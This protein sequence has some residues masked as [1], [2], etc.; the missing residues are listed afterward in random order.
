M[1]SVYSCR[2]ERE[3]GSFALKIVD[4]PEK[5]KE[6]ELALQEVDLL[7]SLDHP[8]IVS[9]VAIERKEI[10]VTSSNEDEPER[11]HRE[12][13]WMVMELFA[14]GFKGIGMEI[15]TTKER[16]HFGSIKRTQ[17]GRSNMYF[18]FWS[19]SYRW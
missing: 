2:M 13:I 3:R 1:G 17:Y 7:R 5:G 19:V 11:T 4:V 14:P 8:N 12:E 16:Q 15:L 9:L 6:R 18:R 10:P